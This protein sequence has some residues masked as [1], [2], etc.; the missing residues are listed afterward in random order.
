MR[1]GIP[2]GVDIL[3]VGTILLL[4]V[5]LL[6][7]LSPLAFSQF[8]NTSI[9]SR[10]NIT[11]VAPTVQQVILYS[12]T[13]GVGNP[14]VLTEGAT[15]TVLCNATVRDLNGFEDIDSTT[16]NA[17]AWIENVVDFGS[18]DD[19]NNHYSN[20]TGCDVFQI[21]LSV[22]LLSCS[23]EFEYYADN[24]SDW[25]C[26]VTAV[27]LDGLS[28]INVSENTTV[29]QLFAINLTVNVTHL[30]MDFG[31]MAPNDLTADADEVL[32]N[33]TNSGNVNLD[34]SV[35]G[36]ANNTGDNYAMNCS[37]GNI[38]AAN[39]RYNITDDTPFANM[40]NVT[41]NRQPNPIPSFSIP[42]R[43]DD[44]DDTKFNSTNTT[45]WKLLV[46]TGVKGFCNGTVMFTAVAQ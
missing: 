35:D 34:I 38:S 45:W 37:I 39:L 15:T 12:P 46:P 22:A 44:S 2:N 42:R 23:F 28:S 40:Y 17:T 29:D 18:D 16:S 1:R 9:E 36:W 41:S 13:A 32:V 11:N 10:V 43:V 25:I 20:L 19:N 33:I 31:N 8:D 3:F 7:P 30:I 5:L 6:F 4:G 14:I 27:D 26:N 21:N 24:A